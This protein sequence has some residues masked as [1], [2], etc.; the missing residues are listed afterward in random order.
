VSTSAYLPF[1]KIVGAKRAEQR[2]KKIARLTNRTD[3][4][5]FKSLFI[6]IPKSAGTSESGRR[7]HHMASASKQQVT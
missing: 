5:T 7:L 1:E 3:R 6:W 4:I 2:V